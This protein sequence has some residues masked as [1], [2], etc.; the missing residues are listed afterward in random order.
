VARG[1]SKPAKGSQQ[2]E[3][4]G[5]SECHDPQPDPDVVDTV[6]HIRADDS[7]GLFGDQETAPRHRR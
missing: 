3:G 5:D 2:T 1:Q 4:G 7:Q 6:S